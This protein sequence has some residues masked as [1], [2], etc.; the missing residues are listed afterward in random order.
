MAVLTDGQ[1]WQF[2]LPAEQGEYG[3]R[4][5]YKLDIVEREIDEAASRLERSLKYEAVCSGAAIDAARAGDRN[6]ARERQMRATSP[7][8]WR[9]LVQEEDEILLDLLAD[10]VEALCGDKP[11]PDVVAAFL[12]ET[13][14]LKPSASVASVSG[15]PGLTP[16][17]SGK[18]RETRPAVERS[19]PS[20]S[21]LSSMD[22]SMLGG[23]PATYLY[24]CSESLQIGTRCSLSGSQLF[25][26]TDEPGA[27]CRGLGRSCT[28][29]APTWFETSH[30]RCDQAGGLA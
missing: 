11:D 5:V 27:T 13:V 1:D 20:G 8:A 12:R 14:Q 26:S 7:E 4:R 25:P 9:R 2:F 30:M 10:R 3:E 23:M 21:D 22:V 16:P 15:V 28:R 6:V 18:K 29:G 24:G 17:P 19:Q